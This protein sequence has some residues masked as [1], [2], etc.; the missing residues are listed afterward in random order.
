MRSSCNADYAKILERILVACAEAPAERWLAFFTRAACKRPRR[1]VWVAACTVKQM[2]TIVEGRHLMTIDMLPKVNETY[3]CG[4]PQNEVD[5][6]RVRTVVIISVQ[7]VAYLR[8]PS[9]S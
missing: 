5:K 8:D 9:A 3:A 1:V 7:A 2:R 6:G 4:Q